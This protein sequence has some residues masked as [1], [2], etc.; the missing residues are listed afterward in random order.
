MVN[1]WLI[2]AAGLLAGATTCA[3]TQGGL[4]VG[5][6]ARQRKA[7]GAVRRSVADDLAPVGG[8][9]IGKLI[10]HTVAGAALGAVG[11]A[12]G[13]SPMVG[14]VALLVAGALMVVLG[15]SALGVPGFK[16]LTFT[17]PDSWLGAVRR[18]TRSGSALAP[19]LLGLAVLLIPCG[20][21]LSM[22]ML[23]AT[24]GSPM[25]GALVMAVFVLGTAPLFAVY[26]FL[27]ARLPFGRALSTALGVLVVAFGVWTFNSGLVA[28]GSP[29]SLP[30]PGA[31]GSG[32]GTVVSAAP[33][34]VQ[35][36]RIQAFDQGYQPSDVAVAAGAPVKVTFTTKNVYSCILATTMPTLNQRTFLPS[37]GS[38]TLDLGVLAPGDYPIA[39][40]MGMYTATLH[41]R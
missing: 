20:V 6:I 37:N 2:L 8:F 25:T 26:G 14:T 29:V 1:W 4:L 28:G 11:V 24:S 33:G 19:F 16:N 30:L 12:L 41:V 40:S 15:L 27:S 36:V 21:T 13:L 17:P 31:R 9:L 38:K 22:M 34:Q 10:S 23:A 39:C 18:Q 7:S 35:E 3:V 5:L 32:P